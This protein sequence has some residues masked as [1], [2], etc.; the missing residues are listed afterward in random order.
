MT[1]FST[2]I[3]KMILKCT[4]SVFAILMMVVAGCTKKQAV[5][6]PPVKVNVVKAI[7]GD[8]PLY[9]DFVAQVYGQSDVGIRSRVEGWVVSVNFR[10]GSAV[11][12]GSLLYVIDD[13][14]YKTRVDREASDLVRSQ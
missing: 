14:Q 9:E 4:V 11:K 1:H 10:E 3:S 12:K 13:A 8:V 7:Q 2:D 5:V 6:M